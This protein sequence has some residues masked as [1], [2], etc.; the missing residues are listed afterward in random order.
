MSGHGKVFGPNQTQYNTLQG[1]ATND[2][3]FKG[4]DAGSETTNTRDIFILPNISR[5]FLSKTYR[6]GDGTGNSWEFNTGETDS[7]DI[8]LID[9]KVDIK[10]VA[11]FADCIWYD[12]TWQ[13]VPLVDTRRMV[14]YEDYKFG[15][16]KNSFEMAY[17]YGGFYGDRPAPTPSQFGTIDLSTIDL[18]TIQ[19][20]SDD[21][22][23]KTYK[24]YITAYVPDSELGK[25]TFKIL[26]LENSEVIDRAIRL[27]FSE[28][29][30]ATL[31]ASA[32]FLLTADNKRQSITSIEST[33]ADGVITLNLSKAIAPS[34][35]VLLSYSDPNG[36]Q[37]SGVIED[38]FGNDLLSI[39]DHP[40]TNFS[41]DKD[42]PTLIDALL[43]GSELTLQFDELL[44]PGTIPSS[45]F[46]IKVN[47]KR[48][49]ASNAKVLDGDTTAVLNLTAP[50]S[51]SSKVLISYLD[52]RNDQSTGV[53]QDTTGNDLLSLRDFAV[54]VL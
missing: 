44:S 42:P 33:P 17:Y 40:I 52:P 28:P 23:I 11:Q 29:L 13:G 30:A 22:F 31:P 47:G 26:T 14:E 25:D 54:E 38:T 12:P 35:K 2:K 1:K 3:K 48:V 16:D 6:V 37:S 8:F 20:M 18:D 39:K 19:G 24:A 32:R 15:E 9:S 4:I 34:A 50:V 7:N 10:K 36:D 5:E 51:E 41:V 46:S 43:D 53:I 21:E 27:T 45:R 49:K